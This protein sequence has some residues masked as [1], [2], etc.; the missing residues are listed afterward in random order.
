MSIEIP[1]RESKEVIEISLQELK[2]QAPQEIVTVLQ[3]EHALR[4]LYLRFAIEYYR[5]GDEFA[6]AALAEK[7]LEDKPYRTDAVDRVS[8]LA[9][10]TTLAAFCVSKA[11]RAR[12][13]IESTSLLDRAQ[14]H[15]AAADQIDFRNH[16]IWALKGYVYLAQRRY[17]QAIYQFNYCITQQP[18]HLPSLFGKACTHYHL[19][20]FEHA[21]TGWQA[22]LRIGANLPGVDLRLGIGMAYYR[23]QSIDQAQHAFHAV[24]RRNPAHVDALVMLAILQLNQAADLTD[25]PASA[26]QAKLLLKQAID[27]LKKAREFD[28]M[29]PVVNL[30][31]AELLFMKGDLLKSHASAQL[32]LKATDAPLTLA[33]AHYCLGRVAHSQHQYA[34][35]VQHYNKS[36]QFDPDNGLVHYALAQCLLAQKLPEQ[37]RVAAEKAIEKLQQRPVEVKK[38]MALLYAMDNTKHEQAIHLFRELTH[39]EPNGTSDAAEAG[40]GGALEDVGLLLELGRLLERKSLNESIQVYE[41]AHAILA[42]QQR[43]SIE[44]LNNIASLYF[45]TGQYEPAERIYDATLQLFREHNE[46]PDKLKWMGDVESML[47]TILYNMARVYEERYPDQDRAEKYYERILEKNPGYLDALLRLGAIHERRGKFADAAKLYKQAM[48]KDEKNLNAITCLALLDLRTKNYKASKHGFTKI[49]QSINNHDAFALVALGNERLY[50]ARHDKPENRSKLYKEAIRLFDKALRCQPQC[51]YAVNGLGIVMAENGHFAEAR[52]AFLSAREAASSEMKSAQ[53]NL[54]HVLVELGQYRQGIALYEGVLESAAL[55]AASDETP[56]D[57]VRNLERMEQYLLTA[58]AYYLLGKTETSPDDMEQC[59]RLLEK[60]K[61][62]APKD[63]MLDYDLALSLQVFAQLACDLPQEKRTSTQLERA[64]HVL[65]RAK[66]LFS[67]LAKNPDCQ[68]YGVDTKMVVEREK[69]G[70]AINTL[71]TRR[72]A[73]QRANEELQRE[74]ME[75]LKRQ[76]EEDRMKREQALEEERLKRQ[77]HER[78]LFEERQKM[79]DRV[80]EEQKELQS[81]VAEEKLKD[82]TKPKRESRKGK[83]RRKRKVESSSSEG[84]EEQQVS[85]RDAEEEE[86]EPE[87]KETSSEESAPED[88]P[89]GDTANQEGKDN[90]SRSSRRRRSKTSKP[91]SKSKSSKS[92]S[93][94][95]I[96]E[97][98]DDNDDNADL[99]PKRKRGKLVKK[100]GERVSTGK[101]SALSEEFVRD[102]DDDDDGDD[103]PADEEMEDVS[104][105]AETEAEISGGG[106]EATE[107]VVGEEVKKDESE[108]SQAVNK[109]RLVVEDDDEE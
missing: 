71:L 98:E 49:L 45:M 37:A 17:A 106:D 16:T 19:G 10:H 92:K 75:E 18:T 57:S 84:E 6:F 48:A 79:M 83:G 95:P 103:G 70:D 46:D 105:P 69:Y 104:K 65:A 80:L 101:P 61:E 56:G 64:Q 15:L 20:E 21:L 87:A 30:H 50:G 89:D 44:V 63:L 9:L 38:L 34:D 108:A 90:K 85:D 100:S 32:V 31:F 58:R 35:A 93:S 4:H 26:Q 29:H 60:A 24:L 47:I 39:H 74:K 3:E 54:A 68:K 91:K 13:V 62:W 52:Q 77:E 82:V 12:D 5:L 25:N 96:T 33:R 41:K 97:T 27:H 11:T 53:I 81:R 23:L 86:E 99:K 51:V 76:R 59:S 8:L 55:V 66:E 43:P 1:V 67:A 14:P 88:V 36:T 2:D 94:E 109:R 28:A 72:L 22:L 42:R 7:G 78:V 40:T 73:Q 107:S 102:S